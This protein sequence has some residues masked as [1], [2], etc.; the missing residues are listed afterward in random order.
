MFQDAMNIA[1]DAYRDA[2]R[3]KG[4][5]YLLLGIAI[6]QVAVFALYGDIS[7]GIENKLLKDMGLAMTALVGVLSG[8]TVA[9][10]IPRE[11]RERTA[12][13]LFAKPLGRE[14]YLLGKVL[15][16]SGLALRNM[17]VVGIGVLIVFNMNHLLEAKFTTAFLQSWLL[18]LVAAIVVASLALL[19][20]LFLG[21]GAVVIVTVIIFLLGNSTYMLSVTSGPAAAKLAA[22]LKYVLP[23]F[24]ILDI[25]TEAGA[26]LAVSE[27]YVAYGLLYGLVYAAALVALSM[28][29]F[30]K[31]DL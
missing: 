31:R 20:S 1:A 18:G 25:K 29:V 11:I 17:L 23:N 7:M 2:N 21:E 14:A 3:R 16:I 30:K 15:G 28:L 6:L 12:M 4:V 9:F 10:Q 8:L 24:F 26:G 27:T 22:L 5:V 19:L 13:T